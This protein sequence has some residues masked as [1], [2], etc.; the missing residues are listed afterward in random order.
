MNDKA[1]HVGERVATD[2]DAGGA[3]R[4]Q[5][6]VPRI[7]AVLDGVAG[8]V[9]C[10]SHI[11]IERP[12]P[13]GADA[14]EKSGIV[15]PATLQRIVLNGDWARGS[16]GAEPQAVMNTAAPGDRVLQQVVADHVTAPSPINSYVVCQPGRKDR[17]VGDRDVGVGRILRPHG[18]AVV[19]WAENAPDTNITITH[20]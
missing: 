7:R 14:K 16:D 15:L 5:E 17:I 10:R 13:N 8:Q 3:I 4:T 20:N 12:E 1:S 2:S 18:Y 11:G 6:H 9:H 19:L